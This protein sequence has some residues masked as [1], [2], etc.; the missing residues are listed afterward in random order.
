MNHLGINKEGPPAAAGDPQE[1][2]LR[3]SA[4]TNSTIVSANLVLQ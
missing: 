3:E 1:S 2:C 4:T